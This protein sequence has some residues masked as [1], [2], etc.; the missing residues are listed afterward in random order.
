MIE[1]TEKLHPLLGKHKGGASWHNDP[2]LFPKETDGPHGVV[3][4]SPGWFQ[5]GHE[6]SCFSMSGVSLVA[7]FQLRQCRNALRL[8]QVLQSQKPWNG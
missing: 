6:V 2:H 3:T 8:A 1:A 7:D 5:Q 4:L